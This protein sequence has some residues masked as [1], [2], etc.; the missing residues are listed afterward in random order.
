MAIFHL[1]GRQDW[2]QARA[3]GVYRP[4]SLEREG[5]IH[6][7]TDRQLLGSA[8]RFYAGRDDLLVLSVDGRELGAALKYEPVGDKLFPHLYAPL[9][10]DLVVEVVALPLGPDGHFDVPAEW[11]PWRSYFR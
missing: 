6:F 10:L 2:A 7:S 9:A 5:F 11:A 1:L 8:E 3:A 4:P